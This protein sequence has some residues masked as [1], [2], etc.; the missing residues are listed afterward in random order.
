MSLSNT[1]PFNATV[2][3]FED[4]ADTQTNDTDLS[5]VENKGKAYIDLGGLFLT[6]EDLK[7]LSSQLELHQRRID[8]K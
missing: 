3:F 1:V 8:V 6:V 2:G 4:S 5:L 7:Y